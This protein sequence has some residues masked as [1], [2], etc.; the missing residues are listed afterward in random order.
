MLR[1]RAIDEKFLPIVGAGFDWL[2]YERRDNQ[3]V[4]DRVE[5]IVQGRDGNWLAFD[6]PARIVRADSADGVG[7]ALADVERLTR[8]AN[9]HAV[10]F[11]AYEA[12][13]AFGLKVHPLENL[14]LV[15]FALF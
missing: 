3:V 12:G 10:G 9:L 15:W 14:P 4:R 11:V 6:D 13:A 1:A 8:D 7:A 2:D 5:A